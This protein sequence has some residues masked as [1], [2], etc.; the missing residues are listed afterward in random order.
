MFFSS[1]ERDLPDF[2]NLEISSCNIWT[3]FRT[4]RYHLSLFI[5]IHV[6]PSL[7]IHFA[8]FLTYTHVPTSLATPSSPHHPTLN[9]YTPPPHLHPHLPSLH[10]RTHSSPHPPHITPPSSHTLLVPSTLLHIPTPSPLPTP[11]QIANLLLLN[12]L[13]QQFLCLL[14]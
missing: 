3:T 12:L 2:S 5:Y 11:Y 7:H 9:T 4:R 1:A 6:P 13:L 10:I 14:L 8:P